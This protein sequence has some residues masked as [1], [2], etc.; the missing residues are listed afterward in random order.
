MNEAIKE[1]R[2]HAVITG[3]SRGIGF[4][5]AREFL[6]RGWRVTVN[7]TRTET[8]SAALAQLREAGFEER[9]HGFVADTSRYPDVLAL[10]DEAAARF[11]NIDIWVNNAG[12]S[13]EYRNMWEIEG[14]VLSRYID[15]NIKGVVF[16]TK[17]AMALMLEQGHGKI[18]N[19]EGFG[20]SGMMRA[21]MTMYGTTKRAV[22]YF[23][24]SVGKEA[25]DSCVLIGTI[26][27]GMVVTDLVKG[28]LSSDEGE[29]AQAKKIF[30]I[31]G[32]RA[33]TVAP[34]LVSKMIRNEKQGAAIDWLSGPK[35]MAR[36]M[37]VPFRRRDLF[38]DDD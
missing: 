14:D 24:R 23:T 31:L 15:I 16:G 32:N 6:A 13:Q 33:E 7:G 28:S 38:H 36:F 22:R 4:A 8:V 34:F 11:G 9:T 37:T 30:N 3:S 1:N 2:Q 5:L 19:M 27:P 35:I 10:R 25:K 17:A 26:S 29:A 12:V 20:S 21:K 18:Y